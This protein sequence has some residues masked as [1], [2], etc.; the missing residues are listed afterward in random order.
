MILKEVVVIDCT[1]RRKQLK[2]WT[3]KQTMI[4][5][6]IEG[7]EFS[8]IWPIIENSDFYVP[9]D[10]LFVLMDDDKII[11]LRLK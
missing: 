4:L 1:Y 10:K 11:D 3:V 9:G 7:N 5:R 6:D 2:P 8:V